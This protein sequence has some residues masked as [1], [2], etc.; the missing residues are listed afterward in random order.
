[1]FDV[2]PVTSQALTAASNMPTSQTANQSS[3]FITGENQT[4]NEHLQ[5]KKLKKRNKPKKVLSNEIDDLASQLEQA[6]AE[7]DNPT[8]T[9][10]TEIIPFFSDEDEV[11][12]H[13]NQRTP[14]PIP[15]KASPPLITT[16][17]SI[18]IHRKSKTSTNEPSQ[19][20]NESMNQTVSSL[21]DDDDDDDVIN[22]TD[23]SE[24]EALKFIKQPL[25]VPE[26]TFATTRPQTNNDLRRSISFLSDDDDCQRP[27]TDSFVL[28][29]STESC[30]SM[31]TTTSS[32]YS[33]ANNAP[34]L[35][36]EPT[37]VS[38][39]S[40]IRRPFPS[41][42]QQS[43]SNISHSALDSEP[44]RVA[45]RFQAS[46][47]EV[48][49]TVE[50]AEET[51]VM[52]PTILVSHKDPVPMLTEMNL[53]NLVLRLLKFLT[54]VPKRL[55]PLKRPQCSIVSLTKITPEQPISNDQPP[56]EI[57]SS[58]TFMDITNANIDENQ[59]TIP[60]QSDSREPILT[61]AQS[62]SSTRI[63]A[64]AESIDNDSISS[65]IDTRID[66]IIQETT[67]SEGNF[68]N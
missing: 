56:K 58:T 16:E 22:K 13:S 14:S 17:S 10:T 45:S 36:I 8:K 30:Q 37:P 23:N 32:T 34:E 19:S 21:S 7:A 61:S 4:S 51:S 2:T 12:E 44:T 54:Q 39:N 55:E 60:E 42:I 52:A 24:L 38:V 57:E 68:I 65:H 43:L 49:M 41:D 11:V 46:S 5:Q 64:Q 53:I 63:E 67:N 27:K 47:D 31:E 48:Q 59:Q 29:T 26:K 40:E 18:Q 35:R 1:M 3:A 28:P 25:P 9:E 15:V 62:S 6:I 33:L 66:D 20:N 50:P